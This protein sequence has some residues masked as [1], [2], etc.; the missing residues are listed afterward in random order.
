MLGRS[1]QGVTE[2]CPGNPGFVLFLL[3]YLHIG[4]MVSLNSDTA[5][6]QESELDESFG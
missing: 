3:E 2:R 4:Q 5:L 6:L 1:R